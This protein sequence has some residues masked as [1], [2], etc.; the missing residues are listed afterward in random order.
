MKIF[1]AQENPTVGDISGNLARL[2]QV[3]QENPGAQL[4]VFPE[5]YLTGYPP[6]D[7]LL[8]GEFLQAVTEGLAALQELSKDYPGTTLVIGTP[9]QD[10]DD[11]FN[12]A[13]VLRGGTLLGVQ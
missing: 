3:L 10:G 7:L 8:R 5:L 2:R 9:W 11:L 12:S 6:C 13:V 4:V 1:L